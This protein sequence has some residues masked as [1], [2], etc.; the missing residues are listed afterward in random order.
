RHRG[1]PSDSRQHRHGVDPG[2]G[3]HRL[4][5]DARPADHHG[6]RLRR[7]PVQADQRATVPGAGPGNPGPSGGSPH[8]SRQ[9]RIL[10]VDDTP[11]NLK[12]LADLLTAKGY[13]IATAA[14]GAEALEKIDSAS[15]DIV[16]LDVMMPGMG[17][18]DV[19]RKIRETPATAML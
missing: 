13:A 17:R 5:H 18:Y 9:G 10:V 7:L 16:L 19:C 4:R 3:G 8:M 12:L 2:G 15:P 1:P 11:V 6:R 14:P